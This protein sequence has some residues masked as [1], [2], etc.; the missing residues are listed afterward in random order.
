MPTHVQGGC[1][2]CSLLHRLFQTPLDTNDRLPWVLM[3]MLDNTVKENKNNQVIRYLAFCVQ[4]TFLLV[5]HSHS[6]IDQRFSVVHR[7]VSNK[8]AFTLQHLLQAVQQLK[9]KDKN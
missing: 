7:E 2:T 9:M 8:D 5:G 1:G 4:L 6:I 3:L